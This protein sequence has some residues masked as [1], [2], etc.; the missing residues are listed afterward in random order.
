LDDVVVRRR[1][2]AALKDVFSKLCDQGP[3]VV[4][5]DDLQWADE[6][7][8][9]LLEELVGPP[10]PPPFLY[11]GCFRQDAEASVM[12]Q[13]VLGLGVGAAPADV[14][15]VSLG[16]LTAEEASDL[17][18][19]MLSHHGDS[20]ATNRSAEI[21][22]ESGGLPYFVGELV[23]F[24]E[25]R[26]EGDGSARPTS[27]SQVVTARAADL[28]E[29]ARRLLEVVALAG[30]VIPAEL[31]AGVAHIAHHHDALD[32]LL[33]AKLLR[34]AG[35]IDDVVTYHDRVR[36]AIVA[37]LEENATRG[38]YERLALAV[39]ATDRPEAE[40]LCQLYQGAH[41][42]KEAGAQAVVAGDKA[43]QGLAFTRAADH[44]RFA[45]GALELEG[46]ARGTLQR[47]LGDA[48]ANCARS[49]EAAGAYDD[50][51]QCA[52]LDQTRDLERLMGE[53]LVRAGQLEDGLRV[54]RKVLRREGIRCPES[55]G[56]ILASLLLARTK[57]RLRG[58]TYTLREEHKVPP[59]LMRRVHALRAAY[60]VGGIN[61]LLGALIM[62]QYVIA[63]LDSGVPDHVMHVI[64]G[65][66]VY[67][68]VFGG[69]EAAR[70]VESLAPEVLRLEQAVGT[71]AGASRTKYFEGMTAFLLGRWRA[72]VTATADG[73]KRQT[74]GLTW[75]ITDLVAKSCQCLLNLGELDVLRDR[76]PRLIREARE[77]RDAQALQQLLALESSLYLAADQP[78][79]AGDVLCELDP[80][81][82]QDR[83]PATALLAL[84]TR[85]SRSLYV[86][87][88]V[89]A[90]RQ[91][92]EAWPRYERSGLARVQVARV[93]MQTAMV[94]CS[95]ARA[96]HEKA[97]VAR[98]IRRIADSLSG[99]DLPWCLGNALQA[100]AVL[101][102]YDGHRA[103]AVDLL[104]HAADAFDRAE[105][106][107][108]AASCRRQRGRIE[109]GVHGEEWMRSADA[110]LVAAGVRNPQAWTAM[111][112]AGFGS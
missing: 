97:P 11:L 50:A 74:F 68:A 6:D 38:L 72:A 75:E 67:A 26:P 96:L 33:G 39:H 2:F 103:R 53:H 25:T 62:S 98:S 28:P 41:M 9:A 27:V 70:K 104:A 93:A 61:P 45:L 66:G 21:A 92:T 42:T 46:A 31:A 57:V 8:A 77:R 105:M 60:P 76:I 111:T 19:R 17:A 106:R 110:Q 88:P 107:L 63:A 90:C 22:S 32:T 64:V 91:M 24:S 102:F 29:P 54:F 10:E 55:T 100:Q 13:R 112:A 84:R 86:G 16:P 23:R 69:Q 35:S 18:R 3:L 1:A 73:E 85:A 15:R 52:P 20:V 44:Y 7:S 82:S 99:E 43:A 51:L 47:K 56:A 94:G 34:R 12:V 4:F 108:D 49:V 48:L 59:G 14:R 89:T 81:W 36:E 5:V 65:E 80:L 79:K 78:D 71:P 37:A 83:L 58:L 95:V 101:A 40:W 87:D 30:R 109:G